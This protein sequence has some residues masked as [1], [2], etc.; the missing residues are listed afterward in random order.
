[1]NT[2]TN[3][4]KQFVNL[5]FKKLSANIAENYNFLYCCENIWWIVSCVL[6]DKPYF[7]R[8]ILDAYTIQESFLYHK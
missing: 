7:G 6:F 2:K 4:T 1:M 5:K 3:K 8:T